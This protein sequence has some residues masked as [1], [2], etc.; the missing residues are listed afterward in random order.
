MKESNFSQEQKLHY[1][2][3]H[4]PVRPHIGVGGVI[5]WNKQVL[6]IKRKYMPNAGLWAIPG[7]HLKLGEQAGLGALRECV[8]ETGLDLSLGELASVIDKIDHDLEGKVEYHYVLCDYWMKINGSYTKDDPPKPQA[9][10]D[11]LDALFVPFNELNKYN[12]TKTV[13]QLFK[14][15]Q[16]LP[17]NYISPFLNE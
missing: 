16:I 8:E 9:K 4:Y 15:L 14:D 10:S 1:D 5:V 13:I 11:V 17:M 2:L 7:G 3:R 6:I 12:L